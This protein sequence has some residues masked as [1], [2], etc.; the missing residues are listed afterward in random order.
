MEIKNIEIKKPP[1]IPMAERGESRAHAARSTGF[2]VL[3]SLLRRRGLWQPPPRVI[4]VRRRRGAV[5]ET[6]ATTPL[7]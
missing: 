2:A 3:L 1:N 7:P 6:S 5:E 4:V